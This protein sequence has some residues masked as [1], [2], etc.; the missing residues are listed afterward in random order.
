MSQASRYGAHPCLRLWFRNGALRSMFCVPKVL[1]VVIFWV[2]P[3]DKKS[4]K[5]G[6]RVIHHRSQHRS[7]CEMIMLSLCKLY[8][9]VW[10]TY[11]SFLMDQRN[12]AELRK[13]TSFLA[14]T[15]ESSHVL[16]MAHWLQERLT[17]HTNGPRRSSA[18]AATC[19]T[20]GATPRWDASC[21]LWL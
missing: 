5:Q 8:I 10:L 11:K 6:V 18:T 20:L 16:L 7:G 15:D 13:E 19:V 9:L 14:F 12:E 21:S 2:I 1:R 17:T 4:S 3:T